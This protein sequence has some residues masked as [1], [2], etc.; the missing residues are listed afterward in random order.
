M[1][2]SQT[3]T[4]YFSLFITLLSLQPQERKI[5]LEFEELEHNITVATESRGNDG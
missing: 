3:L 4:Y 1:K 5:S 2:L